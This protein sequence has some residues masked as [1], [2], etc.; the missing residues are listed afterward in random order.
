MRTLTRRSIERCGLLVLAAALA[1]CGNQ[2]ARAPNPPRY[3]WP[4]SFEYRVQYAEETQSGAQVVS[5]LEETA[6][7]RFVVRNLAY[8][9]WNDSVSKVTSEP[10]RAPAAGRLNPEDT[11]RYIVDLGRMGEFSKVEP[12][13]DPT[14]GACAAAF[15]SALPMEL[16]RIIPRLPVWWA[17]RGYTWSD[18]LGF[19]DLPRPGAARGTVLTVYRVMGDTVVVGRRYWVIGWHSARQAWRSAGGALVRDPVTQE[20]G[21]VLV[22]KA[23]LVPALAQWYGALPAPPQLRSLGVTG[24]G[25]RGRA[26]LAGS[27]FDSLLA[28]R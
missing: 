9:V 26:W 25:Y 10:G 2:S 19:D 11:L 28:D 3:V 5:R 20:Y 4:D 22:D 12:D 27:V 8:V 13:C 24:T 21:S 1:G 17:P 6:R 15:P 14:V 18:T 23:R 7:L 16:R